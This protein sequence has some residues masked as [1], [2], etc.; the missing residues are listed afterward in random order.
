MT[1]NIR[2]FSPADLPSL[3]DLW[4][5]IV[6]AGNA[7]PQ[8]VALSASEA[9]A[10]FA[11]QTFTGVAE[12]RNGRILGLYILHPNNLG[13]CG[14]LANA[15]FA[16]TEKARGR[17]IGEQLVRHC[18]ATAR[19]R[20]FSILQFNAVVRTNQAAVRLYEKLGFVRLGLIPGGF[21]L[22]DGA[23]EDILLFYH[24]L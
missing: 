15:S 5:E 12:D 14:H 23:Y 21:R 3:T 8:E 13:R 19:A 6:E 20:G 11:S 2:P 18:L 17:R 4:N 10:F 1:V 7:F 22:K 24:Q 9:E 16:V